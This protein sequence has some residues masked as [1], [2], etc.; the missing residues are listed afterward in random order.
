[1]SILIAS[2]LALSATCAHEDR[3]PSFGHDDLPT[4]RALIR[5]QAENVGY[6]AIG[7][8][9]SFEEGLRAA[10]RAGKPLLLWVMNGHPLGCT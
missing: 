5:P 8:H 6:E 1:M 10:D 2:L 9:A 3:L 4:W 7:W